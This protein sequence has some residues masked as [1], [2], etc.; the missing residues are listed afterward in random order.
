M[1]AIKE[2][3]TSFYLSESFLKELDCISEILG[4]SRSNLVN[5]AIYAQKGGFDNANKRFNNP[6]KTQKIPTHKGKYKTRLP[7]IKKTK[8]EQKC[9]FEVLY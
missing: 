3:S 6:K 7:R 5:R 8:Q 2:H 9:L 4:I 1:K